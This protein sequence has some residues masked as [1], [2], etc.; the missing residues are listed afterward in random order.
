VRNLQIRLDLGASD[1]EVLFVLSGHWHNSKP[2]HLFLQGSSRQG[3]LELS[4]PGGL[5]LSLL[6]WLH[7]NLH[8]VAFGSAF[9]LDNLLV[10]SESASVALHL[11]GLV[12]SR[13]RVDVVGFQVIAVHQS[14]LARVCVAIAVSVEGGFS[15]V[16]RQG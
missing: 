12:L 11:V 3:P 15:K 10:A 1:L 2:A 16:S 7:D 13:V 6:G 5:G 14:T 4:L 8:A 9:L